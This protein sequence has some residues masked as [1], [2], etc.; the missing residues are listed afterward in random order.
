MWHA[1]CRARRDNSCVQT[2]SNRRFLSQFD[3]K[4]PSVIE[5]VSF[6]R[7]VF[8]NCVLAQTRDSGSRS[9]VRNVRVSNC[10]EVGCAIGPAIL[11]DVV[12]DGLSTSD[13]LIVSGALFRR[14]TLRNRV[15]RI[16]I[17]RYPD[18]DESNLQL[19][20]P[21]DRAS[22]RF[23]AETDWALDISDAVFGSFDATGIPARLI[24]RDPISQVV[25]RRE[26]VSGAAWRKKVA[27]WNTYWLDVLDVIFEDNPPEDTVLVAPKGS[28]KARFQQLVDGLDNLR[29]IGVADPD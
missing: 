29:Q 28:R 20:A 24:R 17:N 4:G 26:N 9:H 2:V 19:T 27:T 7:C 13:L 3:D 14:V 22:E 23:Y 1:S 16:K 11:E 12:V 25:V 5:N 18:I 8:T 10:E 21:F 15:G 6:D